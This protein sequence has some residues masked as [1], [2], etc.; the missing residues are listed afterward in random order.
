MEQRDVHDVV[1]R[2][3][4]REPRIH[5]PGL[6]PRSAGTERLADEGAAEDC[7]LALQWRAREGVFLFTVTF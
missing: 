1:A 6:A 4:R 7:E 5:R 3:R 2:R